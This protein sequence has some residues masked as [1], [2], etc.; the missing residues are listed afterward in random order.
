MF[1]YL[2]SKFARMLKSQW[3]KFANISE[4]KALMNNTEFTV[5]IWNKFIQ[6]HLARDKFN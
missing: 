4:N 2:N 5:F 1:S 3:I 6:L